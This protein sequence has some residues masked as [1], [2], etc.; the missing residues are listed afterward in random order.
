MTIRYIAAAFVGIVLAMALVAGIEA[1]GHAVYPLPAGL[2]FK[3]PAQV[4][5]YFNGL[6]FGEFAF[7]LAA[8]IVSTFVGGV[9]AASI[10]R[11]RPFLFAAFVGAVILAATIANMVLLPHPLWFSVLAVVGILLATYGAGWVAQ[12]RQSGG[13]WG[14]GR[15]S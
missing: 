13:A 10:A 12:T 6:G 8:W 7:V 5:A 2:N 15:G 3:D 4:Q 14:G 1:I 11:T 9:V